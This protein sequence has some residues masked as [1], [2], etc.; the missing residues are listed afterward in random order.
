MQAP[1]NSLS[2]EN[3]LNG[4]RDQIE[5]SGTRAKRNHRIERGQASLYREHVSRICFLL[6][7]VRS[8]TSCNIVPLV[9]IENCRFQREEVPSYD[10][11][12]RTKEFLK[13]K[14]QLRT[15]RVI[16]KY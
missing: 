4:R 8:L 3:P 16:L 12:S 7:L 6:S 13:K 9:T 5:T 11:E 10:Q 14:A 2:V 15:T 1:R